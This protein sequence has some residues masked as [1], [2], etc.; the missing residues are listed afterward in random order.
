MN[1]RVTKTP[2]VSR[3]ALVRGLLGGTG[4]WA[5]ATGLPASF[6][7]SPLASASVGDEAAPQFLILSS[8]DRGDPLNANCPGA[9]AHAGVDHPE[10]EAF[11]KTTVRL[12]QATSEAAQ[13]WSTL[14]PWVLARSCFV[15]HATRSAVHSE[16]PKVLRLMGA[17][18]DDEMLPSLI[19]KAHAV[20]LGTIQSAPVNIGRNVILTAGGVALPRFRPTALKRLLTVDGG[21]LADLR[22]IRDKH[23]DQLHAILKKD[24]TT[25]QRRYLDARAQSREDARKL[26]DDAVRI[27][28][29]VED[30]SAKGELLAAVALFKLNV[31]PVV[32]V[33]V[34]FGGDNHSDA[35][36]QEE[37]DQH[38]EGIEA[39]GTL[40]STLM[41]EGLQDSVTFALMNVFGRNLVSD[42]AGGRDHW[43][44]HAVSLLVGSRVRAGVVGGIMP[45]GDDFACAGIDA[46]SGK[47]ASNGGDVPY[48]DTLAAVGKT[49]WAAAGAD[50]ATVDA[51]IARGKVIEG[52]LT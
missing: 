11:A 48:D 32:C 29:L 51:S 3:R 43:S 21:P 30:D 37:I 15:H 5:I 6:L 25:E 36:L 52:A 38:L 14:P 13:I 10:H 18:Q 47:A 17:T 7:R 22:S 26:A 31:T 46:I 33:S 20:G 16:M 35:G 28:E 34:P 50:C 2:A 4:L 44:K 24:G 8:S 39:L 41:A 40:M 19:A 9:Y 42:V 1:N 45:S 12:G 23:M 27:F 49:I